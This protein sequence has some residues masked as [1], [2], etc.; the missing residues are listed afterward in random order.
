[1]STLNPIFF[2]F[3]LVSIV[4]CYILG[5]CIVVDCAFDSIKGIHLNIIE[6]EIVAMN[7]VHKSYTFVCELFLLCIIEEVWHYLK[8]DQ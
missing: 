4:N 6:L 5:T 8:K 7:L 1:M 2:F 3:F